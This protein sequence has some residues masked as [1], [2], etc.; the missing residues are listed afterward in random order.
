MDV[1]GS[2]THEGIE[3][4]FFEEFAFKVRTVNSRFY[5]VVKHKRHRKVM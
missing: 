4:I 3:F 5:E 1:D 2:E